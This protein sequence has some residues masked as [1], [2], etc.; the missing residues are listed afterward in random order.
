MLDVDQS[1][2]VTGASTDPKAGTTGMSAVGTCAIARAK[3]W[4]LPAR[5]S[6]GST[7]IKVTY[8]TSLR[9]GP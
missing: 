8:A 5:G 3:T 1:G 2:S 4:K 6:K 9:K 7:R